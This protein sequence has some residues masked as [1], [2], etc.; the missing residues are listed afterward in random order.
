MIDALQTDEFAEE[1]A[2]LQ[3]DSAAI[4]KKLIQEIRADPMRNSEVMVSDYKGLRKRRK[5]RIRILFAYC[6]D[7]RNRND[8]MNRGCA[9]CELRNDETVIFFHVGLKGVLY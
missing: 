4:A 7:C 1:Y 5:S 6:R 2:E 9:L 3:R 8:Q